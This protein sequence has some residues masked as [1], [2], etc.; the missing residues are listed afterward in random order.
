MEALAAGVPLVIR[1]RPVLREVFGPAA[2]FAISPQPLPDGL[3]AALADT[4][5]V[6]RAAGPG[7]AAR[8]TVAEAAQRCLA[9]YRDRKSV[10]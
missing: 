9:F 7:L 3:G 4:D 5:P 1:D 2:R 8:H 6:R 10:V